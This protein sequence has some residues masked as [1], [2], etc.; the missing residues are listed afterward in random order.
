LEQFLRFAR[1]QGFGRSLLDFQLYCFNRAC[2]FCQQV[3]AS[4][5][6]AISCF[7]L[8]P[9]LLE[10]RSYLLD[11][12]EIRR[13]IG[14]LHVAQGLKSAAGLRAQVVEPFTRGFDITNA[15]ESWRLLINGTQRIADF[16]GDFDLS[17]LDHWPKSLGWSASAISTNRSAF[18][19][20]DNTSG[21]P[22]CL[23]RKVSA[24]HQIADYN[25]VRDAVDHTLRKAASEGEDPRKVAELVLK[26]ARAGSPRLRYGVGREAYWLPYLKVLLPQS[27]FDYLMRRG[28]GL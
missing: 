7:L 24:A 8:L 17:G 26:I 28:F 22:N 1:A 9:Q 15:C 20:A 21:E 23:V 11:T 27:L 12:W 19:T 25:R 4:T 3:S 2:A 10:L 5:I 13:D 16:V 18:N 14:L 6:C